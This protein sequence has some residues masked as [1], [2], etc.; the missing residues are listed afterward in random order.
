MTKFLKIANLEEESLA[1]IRALENDLGVHIMAF[2]PG[3]DIASLPDDK[4]ERIRALEEKL[5]VTLL[6]YKDS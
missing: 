1:Q 2:R 3:L 6:V 5:G 4:V